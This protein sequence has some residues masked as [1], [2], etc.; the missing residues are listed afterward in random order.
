M[1]PRQRRCILRDDSVSRRTSWVRHHHT[2]RQA[3]RRV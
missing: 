1:K 2:G 3:A